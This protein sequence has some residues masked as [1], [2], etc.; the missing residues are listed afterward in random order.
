[1]TTMEKD[2]VDG[3][4]G[5]THAIWYGYGEDA[6]DFRLVCFLM[7]RAAVRWLRGVAGIATATV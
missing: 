1:M 4:L 7:N 2:S 6:S 3:L 5:K